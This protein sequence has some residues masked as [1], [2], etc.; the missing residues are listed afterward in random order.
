MLYGRSADDEIGRRVAPDLAQPVEIGF[1]PTCRHHC[2]PRADRLIAVAGSYG[3]P[4]K[5]P[6]D[7]L[8][9]NDFGIVDDPNPETVRR[10]VVAVHERLA[11]A[12]K[13]RVGSSQMQRTAQRRLKTDTE[14]PHP[15]RTARRSTN[16]EMRQRFVGFMPA[17]LEQ[18]GHKFVFRVRV[19][20]Q[21]AG[22]GVHAPEVARVAT[23]SAAEVPWRALD[24]NDARAS[25]ARRQRGA[26]A[27]VA[28]AEHCD[29]VDFLL[30]VN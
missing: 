19:A 13:E 22:H 16:G 24:D 17:D 1:E 2:G 11:A 14:S 18:V 29:V 7:E 9:A 15:L 27:R 28:A 6:I 21:L 26:Q 5:L 10:G 30:V 12:Q 20:Q 3:R 25:F 23:V 4:T 8:E